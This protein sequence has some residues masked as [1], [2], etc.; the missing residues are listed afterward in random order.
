MLELSHFDGVDG[1]FVALVAQPASTTVL[2]LFEI[3]GGEQAVDDGNGAGG[4]EMGYALGDALTDVVEMGCLAA[5][6]A[7]QDNDGVVGR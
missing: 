4:V 3:V 5:D 2:G 7:A 1:T 6:D